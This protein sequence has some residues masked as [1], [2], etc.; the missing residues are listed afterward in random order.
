MPLDS[1]VPVMEEELFY[2]YQC[3]KPIVRTLEDALPLTPPHLFAF[4]PQVVCTS[5]MLVH[6]NPSDMVP[7]ALTMKKFGSVLCRYNSECMY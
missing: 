5:H 7:C 1:T 3:L 2:V 6:Q 4:S